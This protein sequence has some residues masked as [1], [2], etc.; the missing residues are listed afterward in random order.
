MLNIRY[1]FIFY[2][3][4]LIP[5]LLIS[6]FCWISAIFAS[7][8]VLKNH[9]VFYGIFIFFTPCFWVKT[10]TDIVIIL[11]LFNF[12][13]NELYFYYNQ[14]IRRIHLWIFTLVIDYLILVIGFFISGF[15]I[16]IA[17]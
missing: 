6:F 4:A 8:E 13:P 3:R 11:F 7:L 2:R 17:L 14:G 15:V 16:R 5:S 10:I 1:A 9:E 12:K